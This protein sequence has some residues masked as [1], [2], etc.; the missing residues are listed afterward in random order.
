MPPVVG[1][2]VPVW[3][4]IVLLAMFT[5]AGAHQ[6]LVF[7][8]VAGI[9]ICC[10][11]FYLMNMRSLAKLAAERPGESICTFAR[12]FDCR[13]VDTWIIRAV[14]EAL[15]PYC[16]FSGGTMP[17]RASDLLGDVLQI[18]HEELDDLAIEIAKRVGR[19]MDRFVENPLFGKVNTVADLVFFLLNQPTN[20][21]VSRSG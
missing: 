7:V 17:L 14:F 5:W 19:S 6:P 16:Q 20:T 9:A 10:F 15:Q 8:V 11:G 18:D 2:P 12:S 4:W 3:F 21:G 13:V 1:R